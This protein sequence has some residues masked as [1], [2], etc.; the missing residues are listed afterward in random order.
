MNI[1]ES[2]K[3]R[4]KVTFAE[5]CSTKITWTLSTFHDDK[6]DLTDKPDKTDEPEQTNKT[7]EPD[8]TYKTD[9]PDKT[10]EPEQT[11]KTDTD[12]SC[13]EEAKPSQLIRSISRVIDALNSC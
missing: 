2:S 11:N 12:S 10:D 13:D 6:P 8:Q 1:S 3:K 4:R 5:P 7:D 9:E